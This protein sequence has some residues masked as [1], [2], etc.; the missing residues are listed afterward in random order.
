M[1]PLDALEPDAKGWNYQALDLCTSAQI[2]AVGRTSISL[3]NWDAGVDEKQHIVLDFSEFWLPASGLYP[4]KRLS[5][6]ALL[7]TTIVLS[8]DSYL[9]RVGKGKSTSQTAL[10]ILRFLARAWEWGYLNDLY[11]PCDWTGAHFRRL[12]RQLKEGGWPRA[13]DIKKRTLAAMTNAYDIDELLWPMHTTSGNPSVRQ[14]G[15][16]AWLHTNLATRS[17]AQTRALLLRAIH[18]D[19]PEPDEPKY[20]QSLFRMIMQELQR[21]SQLEAPYGFSVDPL[22]AIGP[23]A[24][25]TGVRSKRTPNLDVETAVKLLECSL[26]WVHSY[27]GPII[28]LV[29]EVLDVAKESHGL[30][31]YARRKKYRAFLDQLPAKKLVGVLTGVDLN[32][33]Q[34]RQA[35]AI[36]MH[37]LVGMLTTAAF[38]VIAVMNA[39]R[40]DE[41]CHPKLGLKTGAIRIINKEFDIYEGTFYIEKSAKSYVDF[42]VNRSTYVA[43]E[44]LENL[45][46]L[47]VATEQATSLPTAD[48]EKTSLFWQRPVRMVDGLSRSRT[49]FVFDKSPR[50]VASKFVRHAL[51]GGEKT[52]SIASHMFRRF[53]AL[54]FIYRY[55]NGTLQAL[56]HQ[57]GHLNLAV[58]QRYVT[59]ASHMLEIERIPIDLLKTLDVE[60]QAVRDDQ[61]GIAL[62]L[63][64]VA[65][66]KLEKTVS[67]LL[68]GENLSGGFARL[69]RRLHNKLILSVDYSEMDRAAQARR[70]TQTLVQRGHSLQAFPH[71]ECM[72]GSEGKRRAGNCY[73]TEKE[74]LDR[75]TA[76]P[77]TCA[78]CPYHVVSRGYLQAQR[79]DLKAL[80]QQA[81]E[82]HIG[83]VQARRLSQEIEN[84]LAAI[85]LHSTRLEMAQ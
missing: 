24:G 75:S 51:G 31:D 46:K 85:Q 1:D 19:V 52:S 66:E 60:A 58:T 5:E 50:S 72:A 22:T 68:D 49:W 55:E 8:I 34:G 47:Y 39:R 23:S 78:R 70:L 2:S 42:F 53:Y 61:K 67:G 11:R 77:M 83:S 45:N 84:L 48:P 29:E 65:K 57:F 17:L 26:H 81:A 21:V 71:G 15:V 25:K 12:W 33:T 7:S 38:I 74:R 79:N 64:E 14:V 63:E 59:D 6:D 28:A 37:H 10:G 35:G 18:I 54:I 76:S 80:E 40:R 56:A 82:C 9:S 32:L 16:Q 13:L 43:F 73:S 62:V 69:V 20:S 27:S 4:A 30:N 41:I 44:V 3:Q 36:M